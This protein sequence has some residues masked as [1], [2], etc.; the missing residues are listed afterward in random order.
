VLDPWLCYE[1]LGLRP[2]APL[3]EVK[4][5]YRR[6]IREWHPD[7][8]SSDPRKREKAEEYTKALNVAYA[9]LARLLDFRLPFEFVPPRSSPRP[10]G[11]A[12]QPGESRWAW[13]LR[14][15]VDRWRATPRRR[16]IL[17]LSFVLRYFRTDC[18]WPLRSAAAVLGLGM[19]GLGV[20]WLLVVLVASLPVLAR[21]LGGNFGVGFALLAAMA[22]HI[23]RLAVAAVERARTRPPPGVGSS[24]R[25]AR[26]RS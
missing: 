14:T 24:R 1:I 22:F 25:T 10:P 8:F 26:S 12:R 9:T 11:A 13:S 17:N 3:A 2:G 7:R 6:L 18:S 20:T 15:A 16:R 23:S 21:S 4:K 5:A 19:L